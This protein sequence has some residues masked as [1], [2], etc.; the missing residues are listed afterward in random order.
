MQHRVA[1][2]AALSTLALAPLARAEEP[3]FRPIAVIAIAE[4]S[5]TDGRADKPAA[6]PREPLGLRIDLGYASAYNYRGLNYFG[7][8]NQLA[9][10]G[11]LAPSVSWTIG[12][13]GLSLAY[14][15]AY[16]IHGPNPGELMK[17]GYGGEQDLTLTYSR[18]FTGSLSASAWIAGSAYPFASPAVAGTRVPVY[19]DPGASIT[20]STFVDLSLSASFMVGLQTAIEAY[21]YAYLRPTV[22][23]KLTINDRVAVETAAGAGLKLFVVSAAPPGNRVDLS[24]DVRVPIKIGSGYVAPGIHYAWSD[25]GDRP[26]TTGHMVF[27]S[28]NTGI[29][30]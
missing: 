22:A 20:Y 14:L 15:S 12:K 13:T 26:A 4:L 18:S 9:Q 1:L 25:V 17:S 23:R 11:M 29:D 28:F 16:P 7:G 24:A 27:G 5:A 21:R 3:L 2:S 30:L 8:G 10:R 19:L 6:P